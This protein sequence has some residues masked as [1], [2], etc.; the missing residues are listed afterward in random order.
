MKR[1]AWFSLAIMMP[2][3]LA[4]SALSVSAQDWRYSRGRYYRL[5]EREVR[6]IGR[7]NGYEL[8]LREGR[9]EARQGLR[10]N[11]KDNWAYRNGMIGYR[12]EYHHDG[13]YKSGFRDG[14][15]DGYRE[16]YRSFNWRDDRGRHR[17]WWDDGR[18]GR[19]DRS[20]FPRY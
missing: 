6:E 1:S 20:R 4:G 5:S 14:F 12:G 17:P 18:Y 15:E 7:R 13:N 11:Y 9:R 3:L 19:D 2:L 8:G 10:F 16:G